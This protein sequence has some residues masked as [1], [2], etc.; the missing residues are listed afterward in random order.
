[1]LKTRE[2]IIWTILGC[3]IGI[4]ISS[5]YWSNLVDSIIDGMFGK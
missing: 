5:I 4:V 3:I 2:K 1:M